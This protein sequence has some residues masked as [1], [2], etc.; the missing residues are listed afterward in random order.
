MV[1]PSFLT[2]FLLLFS[3]HGLAFASKTGRYSSL[4]SFGDS[5]SDTGNLLLSGDN[6]FIGIAN[7]PYGQTFFKKPTG[8]C[9]DGR[10]IVDFFAEALGLPFLPPYL[11]KSKSKKD[12]RKGMNFAV[13]GATA[14]SYSYFE[15][16][17][18]GLLWTNKSLSVQL[19]WFQQFLPSL[20][21]PG[22][23]CK[24][25]LKNSLF[26]VGEIGGNDFN[27]PLLQ[28][29]SL[30]EARTY[31]PDVIK[32]IT[33]A[34][35]VLI[36][37]GAKTLV[38][39]GNFPTGCS[40]LYLTVFQ[41]NNKDEYEP[42]TGCLIRFN[43]FASYYNS[44]LQDGIQALRK[45][46]PKATIIYA[47]NYNMSMRFVETPT[48]FG[49]PKERVLFACCGGGGPYNFDITKT[50]GS[51]RVKACTY[52]AQYADWDGLHLTEAAYEFIAKAM[53]NGEF[54]HPP[55]KLGVAA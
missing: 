34:V 17:G 44:K 20:C 54:M 42:S 28:A 32:A 55:I 6:P 8:R 30:H 7:P 2:F 21:H 23:D 45:R 15:S 1:F 48:L 51:P 49:F 46:F 16:R 50:C 4:F 14:L 22:T 53:L 26:L 29:R 47:D 31:V 52:P 39:P 18:M 33:E 36:R 10:L 25:Y 24:R 12:F 43:E 9:S 38:V 27:Y 13:A 3:L 19:E 35:S 40:T 37:L 41:T 5:I 11:S